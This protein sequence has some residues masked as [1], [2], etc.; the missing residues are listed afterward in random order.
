MRRTDIAETFSAYS[1][2]VTTFDNDNYDTSLP[3]ANKIYSASVKKA[4]ERYPEE[5][6]L[7]RARPTR[8]CACAHRIDRFAQLCAQKAAGYSAQAYLDYVSWEREVKRPDVVLV[9]QLFERAIKDHPQ[10]LELWEAYLEFLVSDI[11][12][13]STAVFTN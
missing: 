10:E 12:A 9:K 5:E 4:D 8:V 11:V 7:V 6:K 13:T 1:T 3:A 2:F